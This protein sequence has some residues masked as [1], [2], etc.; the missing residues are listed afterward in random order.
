MKLYNLMVMKY[1]YGMSD[2]AFGHLLRAI[3]RVIEW[4]MAQEYSMQICSTGNN[5]SPIQFNVKHVQK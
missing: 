3:A 4:Q 1:L 5:K 2:E